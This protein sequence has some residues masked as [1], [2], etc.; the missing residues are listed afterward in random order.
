M[1]KIVFNTRRTK[2]IEIQSIPG[3][4][5]EVYIWMTVWENRDLLEKYWLEKLSNWDINASIDIIMNNI[6][7]WNFT[8]ELWNDLE[9]KK[10][11]IEQMSIKDLQLLVETIAE[12]ESKKKD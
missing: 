1:S 7:S 6:K 5:I 4:E 9:I 10:K 11:Y 3:S 2:T 8:D 12:V